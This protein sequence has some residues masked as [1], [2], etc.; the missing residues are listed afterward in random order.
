MNRAYSYCKPYQEEVSM[1]FVT[2]SRYT[3]V[4]EK[5]PTTPFRSPFIFH[6]RF[7]SATPIPLPLSHTL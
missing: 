6:H 3:R 2:L 5:K 1:T 4:S 7:T